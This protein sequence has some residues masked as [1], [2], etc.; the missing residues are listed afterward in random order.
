MSTLA[1]RLLPETV[2]SLGFAGIGAAYMGIGG[3]FTNPIRILLI[4]NLTDANLMFSMNGIDDHFPVAANGFLLLDVTSNK[5]ING[6]GFFIAEQTRIYVKDL[7]VPTSGS[8]YVSAFYG[9]GNL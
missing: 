1:I 2:R 8:V 7:D 4:T 6:G 3:V 9:S 5:T